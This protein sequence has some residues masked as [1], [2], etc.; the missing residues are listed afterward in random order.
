MG[1]IPKV[2]MKAVSFSMSLSTMFT[3]ELEGDVPHYPVILV[4]RLQ[5]YTVELE[6]VQASIKS[7]NKS[8]ALGPDGL[9]PKFLKECESTVAEPIRM[10][11]SRGVNNSQHHTNLQER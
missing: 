9:H 6:D 1:L 3:Q 11:S 10:R 7:L 2:I 8:S 4:V 5:E